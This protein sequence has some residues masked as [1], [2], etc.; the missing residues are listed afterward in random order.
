M[1]QENIRN[2]CIIAHVDHGK[3]T[4]AD[5]FLE[6]TRTIDK[7]K[8]VSQT[9][10]SM[11]LERE[12]GITIKLKAVRMA[13]SLNNEDYQLNLIDTPGHVDFSYEVSRS[14][15]ACEGA[16]LVVDVTQG[17]QA[18]TVS[19]VYKALEANLAI[20]PV[21]NKIDIDPQASEGLSKELVQTFGFNENDILRVSAKTGE[22]VE[23]LLKQTI[24]RI[25]SPKGSDKA[26]LRALVFDS[27]YH[28]YLG[29]VAVIKIEEGKLESALIHKREK[30]KFLATKAESIP[31]EIGFF[32]PARKATE[33]L[34]TG[35]VGY[36][37]TGLKDIHAVRVGDT[38]A[39]EK[40]N[41]V[42]LPGYKEVKPFVFISIYPIENDK[43]T[44]LREALE[45]LSL[46]DAALAYE[47]ENNSA[48]GFGFRCG[49]LG[50]LHGEIVQERLEREYGLE[51]ISTTPTVEYKVVL[52][53]GETLYIRDPSTMPERSRIQTL[54]E[55]WIKLNIVS[56][57]EYVGN[58][59]NLCNDR[60]G[61]LIKMDYPSEKKVVFE[62]ELPLAELVYNFFDDLKST[63]AGYA[64]LDYEFSSYKPVNAVKMDIL[65]HNQ[66]VEPLS[67][68]VLSSKAEDV[69]RN[70]LKKLKEIIP[71]QQFKVSL[72][73]AVGGK[74]IA[75]EDIPALRKNV[76]AKMSG[77]HRERKDKLLEE[78]KK[79]KARLKKFG[80]VEIPQ[81]AFRQIL[82]S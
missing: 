57:S 64:S 34:N 28:E 80:K 58:I 15:A 48:L 3:S 21:L 62:Y 55:P 42:P 11:D 18:Q 5:R 56:P 26:T 23:E 1:K 68:I 44:Q 33:T 10:D 7:R 70:L 40:S 53:G 59:L 77:G 61:V 31:E 8:M 36:V 24:L 76:L 38:I 73:A 71:R 79:G 66:I 51:L 41:V 35:E 20:I 52:T 17:I 6:I 16:I 78:Q 60:R 29:V 14:L 43:F 45:K 81:E 72:Q 13:Y 4:L 65:V 2:F 82:Q 37:A 30:I 50:L 27:F 75:R 32:I 63:S 47:P 74:I 25:P 22:G 69:G 19:N 9:L 12:K 54:E 46:S 49:F 39:P 67:H